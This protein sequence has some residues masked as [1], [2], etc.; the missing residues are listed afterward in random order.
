MLTTRFQRL[1]KA[2]LKGELGQKKD[3]KASLPFVQAAA[4]SAD[5]DAPFGP[6]LLGMLYTKDYQK[7]IGFS[8]KLLHP[9]EFSARAHIM[10]AASLGLSDAQMHLGLAHGAAKNNLSL[11]ADNLLAM[12]YLFLASMQGQA[13]ADLALSQLFWT[14]QP[15]ANGWPVNEQM[16]YKFAKVAANERY[17]EAF[18]QLGNF[19]EVGVGVNVNLQQARAW[20]LKSAATG[21]KRAIQRLDRLRDPMSLQVFA[22]KGRG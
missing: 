15:G 17:G 11:P 3:H 14:G 21:D 5:K 10:Q 18:Y 6:F 16:A 22:S 12:H 13:Q 20:Y 9:D 2:L 4:S 8:K 7:S 1:G 19:Y